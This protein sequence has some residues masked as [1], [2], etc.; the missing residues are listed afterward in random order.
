MPLLFCSLACFLPLSLL[1]LGL[2][3]PHLM[4]L[5]SVKTHYPHSVVHS[6]IIHRSTPTLCNLTSLLLLTKASIPSQQSKIPH[7]V[8]PFYE[9]VVPAVLADCFGRGTECHDTDR[10]C[11]HPTP[12]PTSTGCP[13]W[14]AIAGGSSPSPLVGGSSSS[15]GEMATAVYFARFSWWVTHSDANP[16]G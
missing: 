15:R 8:L 16:D 7:R 12:P 13:V 2:L 4:C 1:E 14:S 3:S 11:I 9:T 10:M 5:T 6:P